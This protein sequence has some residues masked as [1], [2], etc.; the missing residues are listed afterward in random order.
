MISSSGHEPPS[1]QTIRPPFSDSERSLAVVALGC[2]LDDL[3]GGVGGRGANCRPHRGNRRRAG[4]DRRVR[5]SRG[6]AEGDLHVVDG[7]TEL[8]R[9]DLRHGG[10]AAGA[11]VLHRG[12]DRDS[13]V[14]ARPGPRRTT[15]GRRPRTRPG[16]PVRRRAS[17][18]RPSS[19]RTCLAPRPVRLGAPVALQKVLGRE[20]PLV[21]RVVL[22]VVAAAELQR[23]EVELRGEL[24]HQA[25]EAERAL[26][27]S[28]RAEGQ[29]RRGVQLCRVLDGPHVLAGV[30]HP[31]RP[32]GRGEPAVPAGRVDELAVEHRERPVGAGA[33]PEPLDR[34][35]AIAGVEILLAPRQRGLDRPAGLPRKLGSD[36]RV[37][38]RGRSWSRSRRP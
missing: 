1:E 30:E 20:R 9:G 15:A 4:G 19:A 23:I 22:R 31:H 37:V 32:A 25:L 28:R 38:A 12:D 18:S 3:A 24:V 33:D 2:D 7:Q 16:S 6:V 13:G 17:R 29:H 27:E 11:D 8:F 35:V 34:R 14:G 26:H 21:H 10:R 5:A 36:E